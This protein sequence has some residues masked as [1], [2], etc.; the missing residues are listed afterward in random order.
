MGEGAVLQADA[1]EEKYGNQD[2]DGSRSTRHFFRQMRHAG[3]AARLMLMRPPPRNGACRPTRCTAANHAL[4][5]AKRAQARLRRAGRTPPRSC[6]CR[7]A[8][9]VLKDPKDFRYIGKGK[10]GLI[11]DRDIT[12]GTAVYGMDTKLAGHAVRRRRAPAGASA[13]R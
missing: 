7:R 3:A 1:D 5:H 4:I 6:R 12:T 2:T 11:D 10:V 9:V 8:T 13:A